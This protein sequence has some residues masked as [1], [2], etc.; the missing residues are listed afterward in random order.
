MVG[1]HAHLALGAGQL[2]NENRIERIWLGLH[3][4]Y[5]AERFDTQWRV[6]LVA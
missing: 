4:K 6:L 2:R 1:E 3:V 5:L